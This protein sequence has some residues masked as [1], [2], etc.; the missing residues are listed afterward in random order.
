MGASTCFTVPKKSSCKKGHLDVDQQRS[1]TDLVDEPV[2]TC[3]W[4][5]GPPP[6]TYRFFVHNYKH[7]DAGSS[8][9]FRCELEFARELGVP[10][11]VFEGKWTASMSTAGSEFQEGSSIRAFE[12][13]WDGRSVMGGGVKIGDSEELSTYDE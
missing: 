8:T 1:S 10:K 2:E 4:K 12:F 6:G 13:Q 5:S 7:R 9:E 11:Q 3:F